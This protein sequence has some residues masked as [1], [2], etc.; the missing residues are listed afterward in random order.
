MISRLAADRALPTC[1]TLLRRRFLRPCSVRAPST[2]LPRL[3]RPVS[4]TM[5][6]MH[7]TSNDVPA[8]SR[9]RSGPTVSVIEA[10]S[11]HSQLATHASARGLHRR[12]NAGGGDEGG[13]ASQGGSTHELIGLGAEESGRRSVG[14]HPFAPP[15]FG[16]NSPE[17]SPRQLTAPLLASLTSS[18][19]GDAPSSIAPAPA[20]P[21]TGLLPSAAMPSN[22][23]TTFAHRPMNVSAFSTATTAP[24]TPPVNAYSAAVRGRNARASALSPVSSAVDSSAPTARASASSSKAKGNVSGRSANQLPAQPAARAHASP[25]PAIP[26][27]LP[28]PLEPMPSGGQP[29]P[30]AQDARDTASPKPA[31]S[32]EG[33]DNQGWWSGSTGGSPEKPESNAKVSDEDGEDAGEHP[34]VDDDWALHSAQS[35]PCRSLASSWGG[36]SN[37]GSAE[38]AG[39]VMAQEGE[40]ATSDEAGMHGGAYT[41]AFSDDSD[42]DKQEEEEEGEGK[43]DSFGLDEHWQAAAWQDDAVW[44][45]AAAEAPASPREE[46]DEMVFLDD[47]NAEDEAWVVEGPMEWEG[48]VASAQDVKLHGPITALV[49]PTAPVDAPQRVVLEITDAPPPRKSQPS[50]TR[51]KAGSKTKNTH[52]PHAESSSVL[53]LG[54]W[55]CHVRGSTPVLH[56]HAAEGAATESAADGD[57]E[58]SATVDG[59]DK[60][61]AGAMGEAE[62][63]ASFYV[64]SAADGSIVCFALDSGTSAESRGAFYRWLGSRATM[65]AYV[66]PPWESEVLTVAPPQQHLGGDQSPLV[67]ATIQRSSRTLQYLMLASAKAVGLSCSAVSYGANALAAAQARR[68]E[69]LAQAESADG[70]LDGDAPTSPATMGITGLELAE[71]PPPLGEQSSSGRGGRGSTSS[72]RGRGDTRGRVGTRTAENGER[73]CSGSDDDM[74]VD[75]EDVNPRTS[76]SRDRVRARDSHEE[77]GTAIGTGRVRNDTRRARTSAVH[78]LDGAEVPPTSMAGAEFDPTSQIAPSNAS[79]HQRVREGMETTRAYLHHISEVSDCIGRS[80]LLGGRHAL[81]VTSHAVAVALPSPHPDSAASRIWREKVSPP[82]YIAG[83]AIARPLAPLAGTLSV[84]GTALAAAVDTAVVARGLMYTSVRQ[85]SSDLASALV[86]PET[87][88]VVAEGMDTIVAAQTTASWVTC[89]GIG[90]LLQGATTDSAALANNLLYVGV[91]RGSAEAAARRFGPAAAMLTAESFDNITAHGLSNAA[92]NLPLS[93]MGWA[94]SAVGSTP[95]RRILA[96]PI[97]HV[98]PEGAETTKLPADSSEDAAEAEEQGEEEEDDAWI[99]LGA[100]WLEGFVAVRG[101]FSLLAPPED[102]QAGT[103]EAATPQAAEPETPAASKASWR[104]VYCVLQDSAFAFFEHERA[105]SAFNAAPLAVV[106]W[107]HM[108]SVTLLTNTSSSTSTLAS[109]PTAAADGH[110]FE[111][112]LADGMKLVIRADT[113][114]QRALW[115]R[116]ILRLAS[117]RAVHMLQLE[118]SS[119]WHSVMVNNAESPEAPT[120]PLCS[121]PPRCSMGSSAATST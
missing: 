103:T 1:W 73:E 28:P 13:G 43:G 21:F 106:E 40:H 75:R 57:S 25:E 61:S 32:G 98:L 105:A 94:L 108:R 12:N 67:N 15:L 45:E 5:T 39:H 72:M 120:P 29:R 35:S 2:R 49:C 34:M 83:A 23:S 38:L 11:T 18:S 9:S 50:R 110:A 17:S 96:T 58:D 79:R 14:A 87:G 59:Q 36:D 64:M 71:A 78:G 99:L 121:S 22:F 4:D 52:N 19:C 10:S 3:L 109:S 31:Q 62:R 6:C 117:W 42:D 82:L 16:C 51:T 44:S 89:H 53:R 91:R 113:P 118:I 69:R 104:R 8:C 102:T 74:R 24:P 80:V 114:T 84:S 37:F 101:D 48:G 27:S 97:S 112:T 7:A 92:S 85:A 119:E 86:G 33:W 70:M 77:Y 41:R 20:S 63:A 111:I 55:T 46:G 95:Q 65:M 26:P 66:I 93:S 116:E 115:V 60:S 88:P 54:T 81:R 107:L 30:A 90:W 76:R 100:P 56:I 68:A 47:D